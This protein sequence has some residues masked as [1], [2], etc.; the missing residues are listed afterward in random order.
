MNLVLCICSYEELAQL[1]RRQMAFEHIFA[2]EGLT[3]SDAE[4]EEEYNGAAREFTEQQQEFDKDKLREQVIEALKV[5]LLLLLPPLPL[6]PL[7]LLLSS[8]LLPLLLY[9][10]GGHIQ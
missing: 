7:L 4:I 6:L 3:V 2:A 8:C 1:I 5:G 10:G 9:A